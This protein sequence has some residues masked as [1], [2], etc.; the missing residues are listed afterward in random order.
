MLGTALNTEHNVEI[1]KAELVKQT[2]IKN[3]I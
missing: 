2:K 1:T 3:R